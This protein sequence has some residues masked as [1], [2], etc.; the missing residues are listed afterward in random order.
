M[1]KIPEGDLDDEEMIL[2]LMRTIE[3]RRSSSKRSAAFT[4]TRTRRSTW[5]WSSR[6]ALFSMRIPPPS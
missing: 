2:H 5:S 1:W 4:A 3:I 6:T